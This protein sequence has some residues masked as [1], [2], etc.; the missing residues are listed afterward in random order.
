[1]LPAP[2]P[3]S[4]ASAAF[5]FLLL[6]SKAGVCV[7][8]QWGRG[9]TL[10]SRAEEGGSGCGLTDT[11]FSGHRRRGFTARLPRQQREGVLE[12]LPTP[13]TAASC[14]TW[15]PA[16][17]R[18]PSSQMG[19][20]VAKTKDMLL[21]PTWTRACLPRSHLRLRGDGAT[22]Q[23]GTL[24][25]RQGQARG[26]RG[27]DSAFWFGGED[28]E[29]RWQVGNDQAAILGTV[30]RKEVK[31]NTTAI[32]FQIP[33]LEGNGVRFNSAESALSLPSVPSGWEACMNQT[34]SLTFRR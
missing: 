27:G 16:Q 28:G 31:N 12:T 9:R 6:H 21:T 1:M 33:T 5:P 22:F 23:E 14:P 2:T 4:Q 20:C 34:L 7:C 13:F 15:L 30:G 29:G 32:I 8:V 24:R 26:A 19:L 18:A 11:L 25:P 3:K 17:I 10:G